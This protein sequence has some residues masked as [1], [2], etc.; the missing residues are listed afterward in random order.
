MPWYHSSA[1]KHVFFVR[2]PRRLLIE[3]QD[4]GTFLADLQSF[5]LALGLKD[6]GET[7]YATNLLKFHNSHTSFV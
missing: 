6:P 7:N 3:V 2:C 5:H 4:C 1:R